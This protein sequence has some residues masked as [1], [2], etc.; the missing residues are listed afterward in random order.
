MFFTV[1][2][3]IPSK[4]QCNHINSTFKAGEVI[5][6][7]VYYNWGFIWLN[8]GWVDF[9]VKAAKF[10]GKDVYHF[11]GIGESHSNYDWL[12]K[13]RDRYQTYIDKESMLPL[14]FLRKNDEGGYKVTNQYYFHHDKN[15][16]YTFTENSDKPYVEDTV[17]IKDCTLDILTLVYYMRNYNFDIMSE[18][19]KIPVN[20]IL[21]NELFDWYARYLGKETIKDRR[22][23]EFLCHKFSAMLIEGTIFK[24]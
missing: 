24:G 16:A 8:A 4:S 6:Y 13:V 3:C 2:Y 11:D 12:Y 19:E 15:I 20:C 5:S 1:V 9:K 23:K 17:E 10:Q 22:G 14:W 21:D 18:N 7:E